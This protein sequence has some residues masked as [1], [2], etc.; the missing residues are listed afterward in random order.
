MPHPPRVF[1]I[2]GEHSGDLHASLIARELTA[3]ADVELLGVAGP[4][5]EAAGVR[6]FIRGEALGVMGIA[7]ALR[8]LPSLWRAGAQIRGEILRT[9]P[10]VVVPVDFGA[11]NVRLLRRIRQRHTGK[12]LYY[13]PPR[14]WDRTRTRWHRLQPLVDRVATPF[15]WS[16]QS[17]REC[18]IDAEWVGHPVLEILTPA[19]DR[20]ALRLSLGLPEEGPLIGLLP[21]SRSIERTSLG[22][23]VIAAAR[24]V[25]RRRPEAR[26]VWSEIE[27]L[28]RYD[29]VGVGELEQQGRLYRL[30]A[31]HDILRAADAAIVCMGTAT[32][33]AAAAGC[34]MIAVY[35]GTWA[36]RAQF[37][38]TRGKPRFY[39][40]PNLLVQQEIVPEYAGT[41]TPLLPV[42]AIG[43]QA[44][45]LALDTP[46]RCAQ[47]AGLER[48]RA[49]LGKP[50]ASARTAQMILD[51]LP[52]L[53][54]GRH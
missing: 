4:R 31:S 19:S 50:G 54:D 49:A 32:L 26:F 39:A 52:G 29:P 53:T 43:E 14:S 6:P 1:F 16:A 20:R 13:F 2:V 40:M 37:Q 23:Q 3:L 36:M 51:L 18:G 8:A 9:Q 12:V 15:E 17:L 11:F 33:E 10:E 25:L 24:E 27:A 38:L 7:P 45:E 48:V 22:P 5:M 41:T 30:S 35:A 42:E 21:G 47:M 44:L 28:R 34:P 46:M